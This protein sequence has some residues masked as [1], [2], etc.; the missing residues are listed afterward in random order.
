MGMALISR[1]HTPIQGFECAAGL[2]YV[3]P[4]GP[5]IRTKTAIT[6]LGPFLERAKAWK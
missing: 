1:K 5:E 4:M 2:H 3:Y 6:G